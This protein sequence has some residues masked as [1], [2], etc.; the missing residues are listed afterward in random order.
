MTATQTFLEQTT[1]LRRCTACNSVLQGRW[2]TLSP[3]LCRTLVKIIETVDRTGTNAVHL[4][5]DVDLSKNEFTNAQ[6]LRY[7]GLIAKV[8]DRS[9]HWLVTR[10]G[11]EF[12]TG[13]TRLP[14]KVYVF[15][16][17]VEGHSDELI[18][19]S[20]AIGQTPTWLKREDYRPSV[21]YTQQAALF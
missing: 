3:G 5:Q 2:E 9:G 7:F 4:Q 18:G 16:N 13:V 6:K 17:A 15:H 19:I 10:R 8:E 12:A 11:R 1:A 14:K 20:D 21:Q